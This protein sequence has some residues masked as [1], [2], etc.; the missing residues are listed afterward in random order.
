MCF[1]VRRTVALNFAYS[2]LPSLS[3]VS[4][5]VLPDRARRNDIHR[6]AI[7]VVAHGKGQIHSFCLTIDEKASSS[8]PNRS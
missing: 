8:F 4:S 6:Q 5:F 3:Y 1:V 7:Q 2:S